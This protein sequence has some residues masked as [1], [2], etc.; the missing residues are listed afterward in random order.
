MF[1]DKSVIAF[2]AIVVIIVCF[3]IVL[4]VRY[5]REISAARAICETEP[6]KIFISTRTGFHCLRGE[7]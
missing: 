2:T 5:E 1:K 6:G 7:W 3:A 4:M